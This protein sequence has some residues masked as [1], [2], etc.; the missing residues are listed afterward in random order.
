MY[1]CIYSVKDRVRLV[2]GLNERNGRVE[3]YANNTWGT[4]C[5]DD[6]DTSDALVI[7]RMIGVK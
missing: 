1:V 6:F 7:C 3:V 4:V 2:D 5:G